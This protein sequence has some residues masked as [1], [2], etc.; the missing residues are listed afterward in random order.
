VSIAPEAI[1]P[2]LLPWFDT[3]GRHDLPWQADLSPYRVWVSEVMLQQTQVETVKPYFERFMARFPDVAALAATPQDEVMRLWSGLGY[4]A[5]ARN[6]HS[7]ASA[8]VAK[9]GGELPE[10][11]DALIAL[12]GIGRSTAG[13]ILALA[14]GQRHA[15]LD[16]NVKRVL[17]R[18]Y[19]VED[20]AESSAGLAK[21]WAL[22]EA[23]TP[24]SRIAAYTQ[25]F[26]DLGATVCTRANPACGRCPLA[27]G[28]GAFLAGRTAELPA[29]RRRTPRRLKRTHM[30]IALSGG[31]VFLERRPPQG[32]WGGL[33]APTE[34]A[35]EESLA[36][37][38]A[39]RFGERAA[40]RRL[41]PIRHAFTHFDLDIEPWI[42][43][44]PVG[45]GLTAEG[46]TRWQPLASIEAVGLPAPVARLLQ[47]LK[48]GANGPVCEA[49]PRGGRPREGALSG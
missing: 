31:L 42:A 12:P 35:D 2:K 40:M 20:T 41:A 5:R 13:A 23:A 48:D 17:A 6:L 49:R 9:H 22:S 7:A 25:A 3:H 36:A 32:I 24:V 10:S 44:L 15:I 29:P 21:L 11:L 33:W 14:R 43:E 4:Y 38:A 47:E 18:V 8:I 28:C 46:E 37:F 30:L 26:M 16:G 19:F 1:A 27:D 45:H 39:G 34:F